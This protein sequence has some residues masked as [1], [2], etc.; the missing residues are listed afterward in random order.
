MPRRKIAVKD[1][2][3]GIK[4]KGKIILVDLTKKEEEGE[5]A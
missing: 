1:L 5:E 4:R 3:G 2:P